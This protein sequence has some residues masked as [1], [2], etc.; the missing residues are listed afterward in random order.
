MTVV[1]LKS[2]TADLV[3][4]TSQEAAADLVA[5]TNQGAEE[6]DH[7]ISMTDTISVDTRRPEQGII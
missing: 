4:G 6:T 1:N 5:G 3:A 2:L 7:A